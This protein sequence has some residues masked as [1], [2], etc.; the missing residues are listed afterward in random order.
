MMNQVEDEYTTLHR[1]IQLVKNE[2]EQSISVGDLSSTFDKSMDSSKNGQLDDTS[3]S[4]VEAEIVADIPSIEAEVFSAD[5]QG[6]V[7]GD[8][9]HVTRDLMS[10][11][12]CH[13]TR[14]LMSVFDDL[15]SDSELCVDHVMPC[16]DQDTVNE[17]TDAEHLFEGLVLHPSSAHLT[18]GNGQ[19]DKLDG[20]LDMVDGPSYSDDGQIDMIDDQ[21]NLIGSQSDMFDGQADLIDG[22]LDKADELLERI[23]QQEQRQSAR[24]EE[25]RR[26]SRGHVRLKVK[27]TETSGSEIQT[28]TKDRRKQKR[29]DDCGEGRKHSRHRH[30]HHHQLKP[31]HQC[32]HPR[33]HHS[34]HHHHHQEPETSVPYQLRLLQLRESYATKRSPAP[35]HGVSPPSPKLGHELNMRRFQL[36]TEIYEE[37]KRACRCHSEEQASGRPVASGQHHITNRNLSD[38]DL[39]GSPDPGVKVHLTHDDITNNNTCC[40]GEGVSWRFEDNFTIPPPPEFDAS[41][42]EEEVTSLTADH[43]DYTGYID[44]NKLTRQSLSQHGSDK[45]LSR[46]S[47]NDVDGQ[48]PVVDRPEDGPSE[49]ESVQDVRHDDVEES[50][51]MDLGADDTPM[52]L[53]TSNKGVFH[54]PYASIRQH[55]QKT[56]RSE[57]SDERLQYFHRSARNAGQGSSSTSRGGCLPEVSPDRPEVEALGMEEDQ[58]LISLVKSLETISRGGGREQFPPKPSPQLINEKRLVKRVSSPHFQRRPMTTGQ[59]SVTNNESSVPNN[60]QMTSGQRSIINNASPLANNQHEMT[61]GQ[62]STTNN[63]SPVTNQQVTSGQHSS[64]NTPHLST[65]DHRPVAS[66]QCP[67]SKVPLKHHD[68]APCPPTP[69]DRSSN[70]DQGCCHVHHSL[71]CPAGATPSISRHT[72]PAPIS[73]T[74]QGSRSLTTHT[75]FSPLPVS[76]RE[77]SRGSRVETD[78]ENSLDILN[79]IRLGIVDKNSNGF[80]HN[81]HES[82]EQNSEKELNN[83]NKSG[84]VNCKNTASGDMRSGGNTVCENKKCDT[85]GVSSVSSA[86]IKDNSVPARNGRTAAKPVAMRSKSLHRDTEKSG[87]D[88]DF[89]SLSGSLR[90]LRHLNIDVSQQLVDG[91]RVYVVRNGSPEMQV[92]V[93]ALTPVLSRRGRTRNSAR[94]APEADRDSSGVTLSREVRDSVALSSHPP[95]TSAQNTITTP[96]EIKPSPQELLPICRKSLFQVSNKF[97]QRAVAN[98]EIS[99][100]P[101]VRSDDELNKTTCSDDLYEE[102]ERARKNLFLP[103]KLAHTWHG[104]SDTSRFRPSPKMGVGMMRGAPKKLSGPAPAAPATGSPFQK[105]SQTLPVISR[106]LL[107]AMHKRY[108][109][110]QYSGQLQTC[111]YLSLSPAS[112]SRKQPI[113]AVCLETRPARD[114]EVHA[115]PPSPQVMARLL[116]LKSEADSNGRQRTLIKQKS[117]TDSN[118]CPRPMESSR[119]EDT[120][121]ALAHR[122]TDWENQ[123]NAIKSD[124]PIKSRQQNESFA[125]PPGGH[126]VDRS[127][128]PTPESSPSIIERLNH[129]HKAELEVLEALKWLRAAG[130]PQYSQMYEDGQFPVDLRVVERDHDFLDADSLQSLFRRVE[131]LNKHAGM[132]I[133]T[134]PNKKGASEEEDE[135]DFCALSERWEYQKTARRWSRKEPA[136]AEARAALDTRSGS[137]DSLLADQDSLTG[138]SPLLGQKMPHR[139]EVMPELAPSEHETLRQISDP[140]HQRSPDDAPDASISPRLRRAASEKIKSAKNIWKKVEGF[141]TKKPRRHPH[142]RNIIEISGPV[143]ADK[144]NMQA[145][146][147]KLNCRDI[148]PTSDGLASQAVPERTANQAAPERT[149]NQAVPERTANQAAPERVPTQVASDRTATLVSPR[150]DQIPTPSDSLPFRSRYA[151]GSQS[152]RV[153][154]TYHTHRPS[155]RHQQQLQQNSSLDEYYSAHSQLQH[156]LETSQP[157]SVRK[158][159]SDTNLLEIF[160]LPQDHQPGRFPTVLQNGYIETDTSG[161]TRPVGLW[162]GR[163]VSPSVTQTSPAVQQSDVT[164]GGHRFSFYDNF[165]PGDN[166]R[167]S[168]KPSIIP[169]VIELPFPKEKPVDR[170]PTGF[171]ARDSGDAKNRTVNFEPHRL[172]NIQESRASSVVS[173]SETS[174]DNDVRLRGRSSD[175]DSPVRTLGDSPGES[176]VSHSSRE[177]S[178]E[179]SFVR[180]SKVTHSASVDS[181]FLPDMGPDSASRQPDM[182]SASRQPDMD[183]A[184]RQPDYE[185]TLQQDYDE[186]DQILK[187]LYDNIKD[188]NSFVT[189][190]AS[191]PAPEPPR[192]PSTLAPATTPQLVPT[193]LNTSLDQDDLVSPTSDLVLSPSSPLSP[194]VREECTDTS[195]SENRSSGGDSSNSDDQETGLTDL[196]HDDSL[197]QMPDVSMERRDSGV[198]HSLTRA[199]GERR[200]KKIRWH[201]FQKS[202]RPDVSSRA[203][204]INSL[205]AGQLVR[206]Q[207]LSLLKLTGIME[208]CLPVNKSGWNWMV[209]RFMKRQRSPDFSD[210]NVFGVPFNVMAQR[211][212]QPLPQ[213]V[214]YAM[215]Y[216]R[217]TCQTAVGIFRKSGVK[218]KIQQLRDHLEAHPDTTDFEDANA[219]NVADMLKTYFRD[220]PECLLTNKMSETFRSIYTHVPQPQRLEAIQAAILLLPDENREVLQS[221]LLFLSDISS[222]ESDHQMNASNLAV[223][224]TPTVFQLG[225]RQYISHSPK[226]NRKNSTGIPDPREIMEQKAAHECLLMMIT[227]CKKLFTIPPHQFRQLQVQSLAHVEPAPLQ[228]IGNSPAEVKAFGQERIQVV[229]KEAHDKNRGWVQTMVVSDVEVFHRKPQDDCPLKEWKFVTDIEAPPIE[230]LRRIMHERH[231]W[232][233]DLL[234]WSVVERLDQHSDIFQYV[235]NSMAPHPSRHFC[236]LR[237][238]R[239]DLTKGACALITMSVEHSDAVE[240]QGVWAVDMGSYFLMEPCGSGRSRIT[241]I[242]RVDTRGRTPDWYTKIY[243]FI[244]ASFLDRLRESF[245]QEASGPETKV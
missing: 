39:S 205:T 48:C 34:H 232:D 84:T 44:W 151:P 57:I 49:T 23:I 2:I 184:S 179:S 142:N 233:E 113:T 155:T 118:V 243:G 103:P 230:V 183:S 87:H 50:S 141:K 102:L 217:R 59:R 79:Q 38:S 80:S 189:K 51:D 99:R 201:S 173:N 112:Y 107:D 88:D 70:Q 3:M 45:Q 138:D 72:D 74:P 109:S 20:Q 135:E 156:T 85:S 198:G 86:R 234:S 174:S 14:D 117:D 207:K 172:D 69:P 197:D 54:L 195:S 241:Y 95:K 126:F 182:D 101:P 52:T 31:V 110:H 145:K 148:S 178:S 213:C 105:Q 119:S 143:V 36:L 66:G 157:G 53:Y 68:P 33:H 158:N 106:T 71:S 164:P 46:G 116:K 214:L 25:Q 55:A 211:T 210:K 32:Y 220:L 194:G 65:C 206:L 26:A 202:H 40:P 6:L 239:S 94:F 19:F 127:K 136:R 56:A 191:P 149:A 235:L 204:Q 225:S 78:F 221:I 43:G 192:P 114:H 58:D 218:S 123:I 144:E 5:V 11:D 227:Q 131:T 29:E 236:I 228:D 89:C 150:E 244:G 167:E 61:I 163:D 165:L 231:T 170:V 27:A 240:V 159:N 223:C 128:T 175:F 115:A 97:S 134:H 42:E 224:F 160:L 161:N 8:M 37:V 41:S 187:Q 35:N 98:D 77:K 196:S 81:K 152:M 104:T 9:C 63:D 47:R 133:D 4:S 168:E 76:A 111:T 180:S 219:Y 185:A 139:P 13:M 91:Q 67:P 177:S 181:Y 186:F 17:F 1:F 100:D 7:S 90:E 162:Q 146:L 245:K 62:R 125:A 28:P 190:D 188:L 73:V 193:H 166:K 129:G 120:S 176:R 147:Q 82:I 132:K 108:C 22:Q 24:H 222:H 93:N 140:A 171:S 215:R 64:T 200:R 209:P 10:G 121:P 18:K 242:T 238:W 124:Q 153:H 216:L 212:G 130:F 21:A 12:M 60:Q 83:A 154:P 208:K 203:M 30:R 92:M 199:P 137:H 16:I 75:V 229:L 96:P 122:P 226:R 237:Y 169:G 15:R